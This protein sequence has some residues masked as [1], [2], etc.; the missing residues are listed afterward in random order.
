MFFNITQIQT[1]ITLLVGLTTVYGA[2]S[3]YY[4][5]R[6][7]KK[8]DEILKV[9]SEGYVTKPEFEN[10]KKLIFTRVDRLEVAV[11]MQKNPQLFVEKTDET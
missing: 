9:V 1:I 4:S 8:L 3:K 11:F 10:H 6:Q 7:K 5:D 2:I